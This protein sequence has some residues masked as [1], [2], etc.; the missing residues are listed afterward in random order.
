MQLLVA[1]HRAGGS[2]VSKDDLIELCWGGRIVG[3]DAINRVV[4][5]LRHALSSVAGDALRI[6]TITKVGYRLKS[7][8]KGSQR[9]PSVTAPKGMDRRSLL[10]TG[11][12]AAGAAA[13]LG[14]LAWQ[15]SRT[16]PLS[17]EAKALIARGR[18]SMNENTVEQLTNAT[19]QFRQATTLAPD[20][21]EAWGA[22]ALAYQVQSQFSPQVQ[23]TQYEARARDAVRRALLLDPDTGDAV[24]AQVWA[25]RVHRN[26]LVFERNCR[27]ALSRFPNH[28]MILQALANVLMQVGRNREALSHIEQAL[29]GPKMPLLYIYKAGLLEDV[30]RIEES[31]RTFEEAF[32]I[33]PRHY[34]VWFTRLYHLAIYGRAAEALAMLDG[35]GR[36]VG[37]PEWNFA[38][39]R[40]QVVAMQTRRPSDIAAALKALVDSAHKGVGFAENAII[41]AAIVESVDIAFEVADAYFFNRG[42]IIGE[43]RFSDEQ[44][45]YT[46]MSRRHTNMLFSARTAP[47]RRDPRFNS[48]VQR[49]GLEDYWAR[50]R[51]KP[52]YRA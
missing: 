29:H 20:S 39:T 30:G 26:W 48:L 21:A 44:G 11:A 10:L 22:L 32:K 27:Q 24:A 16:D 15:R 14:G 36:P 25:V 28:P 49:L 7:I 23:S 42:F 18:A 2:V 17:L 45:I 13:L 3:E 51:L 8:G 38:I 5:R 43:R 46:A 9:T 1:L 47:L 35:P 31:D 33:W 52:D 6:E 41:Y 12:A 34:A 50:S 40:L 37:V 19:A 4:S